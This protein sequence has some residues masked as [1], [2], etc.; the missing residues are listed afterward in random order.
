MATTRRP[1]QSGMSN[2]GP[3]MGIIDKRANRQ[4]ALLARSTQAQSSPGNYQA[5]L[6]RIYSFLSKHRNGTAGI[7]KQNLQQ[8]QAVAASLRASRRQA[9]RPKPKPDARP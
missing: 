2:G 5:Q 6:S 8:L 9:M 4:A 1:G 3:G 7:S